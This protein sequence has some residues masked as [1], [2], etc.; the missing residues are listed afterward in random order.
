LSKRRERRIQYAALPFRPGRDGV[1]IILITSR[2][3]KRW[4]LPKGWPMKG[5][6]AREAAAIE[7]HE[8]AGLDGPVSEQP[9]GSYR[10]DKRL[11]D[12]NARPVEV[13]VFPLRVETLS[14]DW[15]EKDQRRR[16]WFSPAVAAALVEE[17]E[18]KALI[19]AFGRVRLDGGG[20]GGLN[21]GP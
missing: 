16:E 9:I 7:A 15:P 19:M 14:D 8:E 17:P 4:V 11:K 10:Y 1:E 21:P 3:T 20:A 5:R 6:T 13:S 12:G 18:L 2:E